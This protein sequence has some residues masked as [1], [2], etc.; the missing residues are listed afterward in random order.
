MKD[1]QDRQQNLAYRRSVLEDRIARALPLVALGDKVA[2]R[3]VRA[4]RRE[5]AGLR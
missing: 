1:Y 2:A 5:L 4:M 3:S